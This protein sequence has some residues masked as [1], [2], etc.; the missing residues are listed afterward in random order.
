MRPQLLMFAYGI[1]IVG[2]ML[3]LICSGRWLVNDEINIINALSSL[4]MTESAG[5]PMPTGIMAFFEGVFTAISWD[6]PYLDSPWGFCLKLILLYPVSL[7]VVYGI[8]Q[9]S[10]MIIS[11]VFDALRSLT[12][13][14]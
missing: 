3:S 11:A 8:L 1:F 14:R 12:A 2:T 9:L 10:V 6:Y 4:H 5:L 13:F 7:G